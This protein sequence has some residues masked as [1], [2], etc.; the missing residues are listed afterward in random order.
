VIACELKLIYFSEKIHQYV[1]EGSEYENK[2]EQ[3]LNEVDI[4]EEVTESIPEF[5]L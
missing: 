2:E 1:L 3:H 5:I 4:L